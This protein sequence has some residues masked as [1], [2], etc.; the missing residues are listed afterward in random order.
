MTEVN[1]MDEATIDDLRKLI[2]A[3][4]YARWRG[5]AG[6]VRRAGLV[7]P[8]AALPAVLRAEPVDPMQMAPAERQWLREKYEREIGAVPPLYRLRPNQRWMETN[9]DPYLPAGLYEADIRRIYDRFGWQ[10]AGYVW[11]G[12]RNRA[13]SVAA[14]YQFRHG[15]GVEY[16]TFGVGSMEP[17]VAGQWLCLACR[18]GVPE[19]FEYSRTW[20]YR[21]IRSKVGQYREGWKLRPLAEG[22]RPQGRTATGILQLPS[23]RPFQQRVD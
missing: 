22:D 16:R 18:D 10:A 20:D 4:L 11:L 8:F 1:A 13:Y 7:A 21:L 19:A 6:E 23:W 14:R 17:F 2:P 9:D 3:E 12:W 15:E 5:L